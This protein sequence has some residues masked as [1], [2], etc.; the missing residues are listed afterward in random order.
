VSSRRTIILIFAL[1]ISAVSVFGIFNYVQGVEEA[2]TAEQETGTY[3]VVAVEIPKGTDIERVVAEGM[4][5]EV[6]VPLELRPATY[7]SDPGTE[8]AGRVAVITLQ[9]N[10]AIVQGL[11][12]A[13]D[14]LATGITERLAKLGLVSVTVSVDQVKSAAYQIAPGDY[15]N[16]LS[17]IEYEQPVGPSQ[18][19]LP[20]DQR[21]DIA[22]ETNRD[23]VTA[24]GADVR[25]VYQ[26][27]E[28]LAVDQ[29]LTPQLGD[30]E[31]VDPDAVGVAEPVVNRG[32]ITLA[33]PPEAVQ[34]ILSIGFEQ[35][36]FSLVP[37]NYEPRAIA[38][39]DIDLD[40]LPG[41]QEELL[42][43]YGPNGRSESDQSQQ[44]AGR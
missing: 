20:L 19:E 34:M 37:Q 28:V 15:V 23:A 9:P 27:V 38:P 18:A 29:E 35:L 25:Y 36:Y 6:D 11:F 33:V 39:I 22:Y 8:L 40:R 13:P 44:P 4:L 31:D 32:L 21:T 1:V 30:T 3:W 43:P 5:V 7:I 26:N 24:F 2:A 17:Y 14:V 16:V 42:T 12:L 10:I 41:E